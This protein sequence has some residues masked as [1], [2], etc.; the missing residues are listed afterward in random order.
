MI[1]EGQV[2][3]LGRSTPTKALTCTAAVA[4][5]LGANRWGS[6]IGV[7]PLFLTDLLIVASVADRFVARAMYRQRPPIR[8]GYVPGPSTIVLAFLGYTVVR[9][10]FSGSWTMSVTW[11]RDGAP[12]LYAALALIS[13]DAVA[14]ATPAVL[15]RTMRWI[16]AA[17]IFHLGWVCV[18]GPIADTSVFAAPR[19]LL[20]GGIFYGK[21]DIDSAILGVMAG[22][23]LRR[24]VLGQRRGWAILGLVAIVYGASRSTNRA[25]FISL[26]LVCA[27]SLG[28]A[29]V[30]SGRA[31][32]KR[33]ALLAL[34]PAAALVAITILPS[35]TVGSRLI[36][37]VS[38]GDATTT[39]AQNA[40]GTTEARRLTWSGVID[41]TTSDQSRMMFG[42][43]MGVDFLEE[44][45]TL[46]YL[47][48]TEY[49]GVRSP[50]DYLIGSFARLGLVGVGL[51]L[52][53]LVNLLHRMA[54]FRRRI[55]EDEL[56]MFAAL[57]V[58][59][60]IPV[61]SFG[62]VLEAPFGAVPFWWAAGLLLAL[63]PATSGLADH[64][65]ERFPATTAS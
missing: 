47:E 45:G 38:P 55:A 24:A 16:W 41:W 13:A 6:Y 14:R 65:S 23:L 11:L 53:I 1:A 59:A 60:M 46:H 43:G 62:V 27:A 19:P 5:M 61:A 26:I 9:M 3:P 20:A 64:D 50:H 28:Y 40:Q 49:T 34:I 63:A 54:R 36:A 39:A 42:A 29:Y 48:G 10:L 4:L 17:L 52:A 37:T 31:P 15:E 33:L 25:G 2:R 18:V 58:I 30:A 21:P 56:L 57:T 51:I 12:Y 7:S 35:T 8:V 32:L 44:S 22:L